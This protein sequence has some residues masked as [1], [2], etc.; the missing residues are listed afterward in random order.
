MVYSWLVGA[1]AAIVLFLGSLHLLFTYRGKRFWPRDAALKQTL[2]SAKIYLT[3]QTTFWKAWICFNA[4]HSLGAILFGLVFGYLGV[5]AP[6]FFF[7]S[8]FLMGLGAI[9]LIAYAYLV[10]R[11]GFSTPFRGIMIALLCYAGGIVTLLWH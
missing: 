3:P 2:E 11:T 10:G 7:Q 6:V 9:T 8:F 5:F 1:S 4:T